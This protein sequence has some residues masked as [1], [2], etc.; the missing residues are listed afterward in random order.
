L[1][2]AFF[3]SGEEAPP[4]G[5]AENEVAK[6]VAGSNEVEVD[7]GS[8]SGLGGFPSG[9]LC[10]MLWLRMRAGISVLM[11]RARE[12]V[13]TVPNPQAQAKQTQG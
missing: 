7:F 4:L 13:S 9:H 11:I 12:N 8:L 1:S 6:L 3:S 5:K 2:V 10:I